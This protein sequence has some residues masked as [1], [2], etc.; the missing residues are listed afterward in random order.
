[1]PIPIYNTLNSTITLIPFLQEGAKLMSM[2]EFVKIYVDASVD[3]RA[4]IEE[5]L[6][7]LETQSSY[8]ESIYQT[9]HKDS[10]PSQ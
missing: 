2:E 5:T 9:A 1:M 10:W 4:Q 6:N 3:V 7:S 8:P